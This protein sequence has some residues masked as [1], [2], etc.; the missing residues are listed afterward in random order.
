M[1]LQGQGTIQAIGKDLKTTV[2][3]ILP[4]LPKRVKKITV[5]VLAPK[6]IWI[7]WK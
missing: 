1:K 7:T 4:T 6:E 2:F 5:E 3:E